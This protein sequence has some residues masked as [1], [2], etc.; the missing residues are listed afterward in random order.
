M[1]LAGL[2]LGL[3]WWGPGPNFGHRASRAG[4]SPR[5]ALRAKGGLI[6]RIKKVLAVKMFWLRSGTRIGIG[7]VVRLPGAALGVGENV[8]A[9]QPQS[10]H[11]SM[12]HST[13]HFKRLCGMTISAAD[14]SKPKTLN[15][16]I[17]TQPYT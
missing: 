6:P 13:T 3:F 14:Q 17:L 2:F 9:G 15:A 4:I 5:P 10:G 1:A 7:G 16:K 12:S 11:S 8:L